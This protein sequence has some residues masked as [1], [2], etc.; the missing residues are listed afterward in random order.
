MR[1]TSFV[2]GIVGGVTGLGVHAVLLVRF[3]SQTS[4]SFHAFL[5]L[6]LAV[7]LGLAAILVAAFLRRSTKTLAVV[8]PVLGVLGFFPRPMTWIPSGVLLMAGGVAALISLRSDTT[9]PAPSHGAV[10]ANGTSLHWSE[11]ARLGLPP[12]P[13]RPVMTAKRDTWSPAKTVGIVGVAIVAAAIVIPISLW[14]PWNPS[15]E[16]E[17]TQ[18]VAT[19]SSPNTT[20]QPPITSDSTSTTDRAATT[21][22]VPSTTTTVPTAPGALD[23]YSDSVRGFTMS[24]PTAWRNTDPGEVGE[25]V[26]GS[27]ARAF[28]E[29][30]TDAYVAA[31]FA[32]WNGPTFNGCYLDYVWVEVWD[33]GRYDSSDLPEIQAD[34][35]DWLD[36]IAD[37]YQNDDIQ[38]IER[39]HERQIGEVRGFE[40]DWSY[41]LGGHTIVVRECVLIVDQSL[42]Y[43]RL[44]T[45]IENQDANGPL[46]DQILEDFLVTGGSNLI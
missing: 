18:R 39:A 30:Y 13:T 24:Y 32:D 41:F 21:T 36:D 3:F 16:S 7:A 9:S 11:A 25:R 4:G 12:V 22:T 2:L 17:G 26:F 19:D 33:D 6:A 31:S 28:D 27:Q 42:Y 38:V 1:V 20:A 46:F 10:S 35:E 23:T 29:E 37:Q 14:S 43:L 40:Q 44:A 8:L 5:Q 45:V 15:A 34:F